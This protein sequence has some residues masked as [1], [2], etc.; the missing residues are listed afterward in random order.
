MVE[1]IKD[2]CAA[3]IKAHRAC[4]A[5]WFKENANYNGVMV[6]AVNLKPPWQGGAV[7]Q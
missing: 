3:W 2:N 6:E 4:D 7:A 1:N 5:L